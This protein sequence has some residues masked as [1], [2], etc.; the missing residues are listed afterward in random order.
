MAE[1]KKNTTEENGSAHNT[2]KKNTSVKTENTETGGAKEKGQEPD[3][4]LSEKPSI[5]DYYFKIL[6]SLEDVDPNT[7]KKAIMECIAFAMK[8]HEAIFERYHV[9]IQFDE[10]I[11]TRVDADNIYASLKYWQPEGKKDIL[12]V[13]YSFGGRIASAYLISKLCREFAAKKFLVAVP[14]QAKSAATLICCGADEIHMGSLSELGPIDPQINGLPA[15][16]LKNTI[17]Q[18]AETSSQYPSSNSLFAEYLAKTIK[19]IDLG[20]FDRIVESASQYAQRLLGKRCQKLSPDKIKKLADRLVYDYNDHGF[21]ID[22]GEAKEIFGADVIKIDSPEYFFSN[23][24]YSLLSTISSIC[25]KKYD[26]Y[27]IGS[28]NLPSSVGLLKK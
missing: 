23:D 4:A 22:K 12:L 7:T 13:L 28:C 11:M 1:I 10:T 8:K 14:R 20:Y 6:A 5:T 18:I 27:F 9:L 16:G 26:F 25:S 21:V 2:G 3:A 17:K 24:V 15:L 19:P